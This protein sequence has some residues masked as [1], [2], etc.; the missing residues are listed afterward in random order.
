MNKFLFLTLLFLISP[1]ANA[2]I[3][4]GGTFDKGERPVNR[5]LN[6]TGRTVTFRMNT[7]LTAYGGSIAAELSSAQFQSAV[8]SAVNSWAN[9]CGS[10]ISVQIG[11]NTATIVDPADLINTIVWDN[12]TTGEG[13]D[14]ADTGV[15]AVAYSAFNTTTD[16]Y[17]DCD[18]QVN[19]EMIADF[20][21]DGTATAYDLVSVLAH[22]IGH[23]LGLDHSV[24]PP[25]FTSSN[26]ILLNATMASTVSAGNI[27]GRSLSQD[28][29]DAMECVYPTASTLKTGRFC[30][31]YHG[32]NNNGALSG[33]VSGGPTNERRCGEGNGTSMGVSEKSGGGCGTS[34]IAA[35]D[36]KPQKSELLQSW[37]MPLSIALLLTLFWRILSKFLRYFPIFLLLAPLANAGDLEFW[38]SNNRSRSGSINNALSIESSEATFTRVFPTPQEELNRFQDAGASLLFKAHRYAS[39]GVFIR[40]NMEQKTQQSA[41][42]AANTKLLSKDSFLHGF[43]TG[44]NTRFYLRNQEEGD[45]HP[46]FDLML[47]FGRYFL[48]QQMTDSSGLSVLRARAIASEGSA[49]LGLRVRLFSGTFLSV[50]GGYAR[51]K[52]N[53]FTVSEVSGTRYSSLIKDRRILARGTE[54]VILK[55]SALSLMTGLNFVF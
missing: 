20:A 26:S 55:R 48:Q 39:V 1:T 35:T 36:T 27:G 22:E 15:L 32:T 17:T 21:I 43:T 45:W 44:F 25:T 30:T 28:E 11:A 33:S 19:G 34:A 6:W 31:S 50:K 10:D 12:R 46:F 3:F 8:A 5:A 52:T 14:I 9:L 29:I 2:F 41:F 53:S 24:E 4:L 51:I 13:N 7:D 38:Y 47:G 23:C 37:L 49:Y 18:I 54:E 40:Y 42:D 16:V